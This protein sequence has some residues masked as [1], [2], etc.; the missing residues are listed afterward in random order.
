LLNIFG[1]IT[2]C[3]EVARGILVSFSESRPKIPIIVRLV[4]TNEDEGRRLLAEAHMITATSLLEAA[5]KAVEAVPQAE[6]Q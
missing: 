4:G 3:D 1:G 2:R 5:R 6:P